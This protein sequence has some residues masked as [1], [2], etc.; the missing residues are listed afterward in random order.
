MR[1]YR[2][3]MR[4][5]LQIVQFPHPGSEH[6]ASG[7]FMD[8]HRGEHARKFLVGHGVHLNGGVRHDA[9]LAFWGEWEPQSR[10]EELAAPINGL[11]KWAHI[12]YWQRHR[13]RQLLQ[14]TDPMVFGDRFLYSNCRQT[15]NDKL[16]S[17]APGSLILF[18]SKLGGEFVLD[19]LFVVNDLGETFTRATAASIQAPDWLHAVVFEPLTNSSRPASER[20]RLYRGRTQRE[21]PEGTYSFVPCIPWNINDASGFARPAIRLDPRILSSNLARG[22]KATLATASEVQRVWDEVHQQVLAAG[23]LIG[24]WFA[25]PRELPPRY[26]A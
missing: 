21:S 19:T 17:L 10:V 2:G 4:D 9:R 15:W 22:A 23:L 1:G 18:G 24:V 25:P 14:N 6:N 8:W 12:P 7:P 11:P 5:E 20:F 13:H 3:A 16:R 26:A